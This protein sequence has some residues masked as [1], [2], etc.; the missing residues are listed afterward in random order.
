MQRLEKI[1]PQK[2][3]P[4]LPERQSY[5]NFC[6][7]TVN[8][9]FSEKLQRGDQE[10]IFKNRPKSSSRFKGPRALWRKWHYPLISIH[11]NCKN[12]R[13]FTRKQRLQKCPNGQ[14]IAILARSP[15]TRIFWKSAKGGPR[16]IFQNR[17]KGCPRWKGPRALWR[18][19]HYHLIKMH[20]TCK[21]W[22]RF[23]RKR[24]L[25]KCPNGEVTAIFARSPQTRIFWK[26]AKGRPREIF[27]KSPKK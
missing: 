20:F 17:P 23:W 8:P 4:K 22:R 7:V 1:L 2:A 25:Q 6:K 24:R 12:W 21:E 3:A 14:V 19:W 15:K 11:L 9:Q 5:G 27:Q 10:K 26:S 16:E 18:K 13:R